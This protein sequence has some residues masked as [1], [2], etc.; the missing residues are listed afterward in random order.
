[1]PSIF[2]FYGFSH[3][4]FSLK[5]SQ[6]L[7]L[8]NHGFSGQI[9][10][11]VLVLT[12]NTAFLPPTCQMLSNSGKMN[13]F[14]KRMFNYEINKKST[15]KNIKMFAQLIFIVLDFGLVMTS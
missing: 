14:F 3:E 5:V 12:E 9:L 15:A 6:K 13:T 2:H 7:Y 8:N 4:L 1:M 11:Q 10:Q